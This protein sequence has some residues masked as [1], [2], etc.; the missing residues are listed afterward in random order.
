MNDV[1]I[2]TGPTAS[3]KT[4]F[5]VKTAKKYN[6][7]IISADSMQIYKYMDIGTAKATEKEM[8]GVP[9]YNLDVV[10]PDEKFTVYDFQQSTELIIKKILDKGKLP[11]VAGGTGLYINSLIY[12]LKFDNPVSDEKARNELY[13]LYEE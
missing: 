1:L 3:G 12:D 2:I 6:G 7:E 11:I 5:S 9:H 8:A 13:K 4:Y 10:F